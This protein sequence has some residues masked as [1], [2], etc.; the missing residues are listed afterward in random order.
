MAVLRDS[1][2]TITVSRGQV[3]AGADQT[4]GCSATGA[5]FGDAI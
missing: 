2:A 5:G 3:Q 4:I 1:Q